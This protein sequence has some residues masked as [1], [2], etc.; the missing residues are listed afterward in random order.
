LFAA[1]IVSLTIPVTTGRTRDLNVEE[2]RRLAIQALRPTERAAPG[3][4]AEL[5]QSSHIAG[6]YRF[7]ITW[8]NPNPGSAVIGS[9]AVN[10]ATGDVWELVQCRR[11]RSPDLKRLQQELRQAIGLSSRELH[12]LREKTPCES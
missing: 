10:K 9:Y 5:A 6:F 4:D 2:A 1:F 7:E 3:L 8:N 12:E 11:M